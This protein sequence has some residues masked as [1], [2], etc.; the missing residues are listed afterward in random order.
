VRPG[1][2]AA[3]ATTVAAVALA[4]AASPG[5][6]APRAKAA[7]CTKKGNL[8]AII[9][10]SFSMSGT[11]PG[12][13]RVRGLD[14]F[15]NTVGNESKTLGAVEFGTTA[16]AVFHPGNIGVF[17]TP[18]VAALDRSIAADNGGTD[19]NAAFASAR[20]E[21]PSADARIF[22]TDGGHNAGVYLDG[23]RG[24]PP[25][26]V[27]GFSAASTGTDGERLKQIARETGGKA[28]LQTD[29]SNLQAVFEEISTIVNCQ[30]PPKTYA[31]SF[32]RNGQSKPHALNIPSGTRSVSFALSWLNANPASPNAFDIGGFRIVRKGKV[33]ATARKR[34][35]KVQKRRGTSFVSVKLTRVTRGKLRFRVRATKVTTPG[36]Q[37][38]LTTQAIRSRRR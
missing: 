27:V 22:L 5:G 9:D 18:M 37:V 36:A 29:S 19:Y 15:I 20:A 3:V 8:E 2:G 14:L 1:P 6:A 24:G 10:D 25:T 12:R 34:K 11:D 7:A 17:H 21:N 31:D 33:V 35:L 30:S 28:F 16:D 26:Y 23:H 38:K 13:L 32:T 4:L